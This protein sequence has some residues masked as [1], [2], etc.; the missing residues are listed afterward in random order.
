MLSQSSIDRSQPAKQSSTAANNYVQQYFWTI[1]D[2]SSPLNDIANDIFTDENTEP[3]PNSN[4]PYKSSN[5]TVLFQS[6]YK[7]TYKSTF[8]PTIRLPH[9]NF[10]SP[11]VNHNTHNTLQPHSIHTTVKRSLFDDINDNDSSSNNKR[12]KSINDYNTNDTIYDESTNDD[13]LHSTV[14]NSAYNTVD[15]LSMISGQSFI[16]PLKKQLLTNTIS[17]D[18][19][20]MSP[21]QQSPIRQTIRNQRYGSPT[22]HTN[23]STSVHTNHLTSFLTSPSSNKLLHQLNNTNTNSIIKNTNTLYHNTLYKQLPSTPLRQHIAGTDLNGYS[24]SDLSPDTITRASDS[25]RHSLQNTFSNSKLNNADCNN[26]VQLIDNEISEYS[27]ILSNNTT[28]HSAISTNSTHANNNTSMNKKTSS[29]ASKKLSAA[30]KT[31]EPGKKRLAKGL[32]HFSLKVCHKV[33]QQQITTYNKVAD[34][35]VSDMS[36]QTQL[37]DGTSILST[38]DIKAYDE[39]NIRRRVY[40]ALNVLM[41]MGIIQKSKKTITWCGLPNNIQHNIVLENERTNTIQT[42]IYEKKLKLISLLI[43]YICINNLI[44]HNRVRNNDTINTDN[45]STN[46]NESMVRAYNPFVF[47]RYPC[48]STIN[49]E[50]NTDK[51]FVKLESTNN[52]IDTTSDKLLQE[53]GYA[54][55]Y[56]YDLQRYIPNELIPYYPQKYIKSE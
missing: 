9:T 47:V 5:D 1:N 49:I 53:L 43:E 36:K 54:D 19:I 21:I 29:T 16:S 40:D 56:L 31:S 27:S 25:A 39:K 42:N 13:S 14:T 3:L 48:N 24:Q 50:Q 22:F 4:T 12:H 52:A 17:N 11:Q 20:T 33:E 6:P 34:E 35:L 45:T 10:I 44:K 15:E 38:A 2:S 32:R 18:Y 55:I 37:I 8:S 30:E 26:H 23:N 28:S 41:A 46:D 7:S 51:S